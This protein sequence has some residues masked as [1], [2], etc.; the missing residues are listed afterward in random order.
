MSFVRQPELHRAFI[1][2]KFIF[3]LQRHELLEQHSSNIISN[4]KIVEDDFN[5][6]HAESLE[7]SILIGEQQL[8]FAVIDPAVY[9]LYWLESFQFESALKTEQLVQ[10]LETIFS[11]HEILKNCFW[12][13]IKV[14]IIN[15]KSTLL[16]EALFDENQIIK[17]FEI[18]CAYQPATE[19]VLLYRHKNA[20]I[21][22]LFATDKLLYELIKTQFSSRKVEFIPLGSI[23]IEGILHHTHSTV[24]PTIYINI[25]Y[26]LAS[27]AIKNGNQL[28]YFNSFH[29]KDFKDLLYYILFIAEEFDYT[30]EQ[31]T[32]VIWGNTGVETEYHIHLKDYINTVVLGN[33]ANAVSASFKFS[34]I[35]K[36]QFF[37]LLS[38]PLCS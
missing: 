25:G 7:L 19:Y 29:I 22:N 23:L 12:K 21:V 8:S 15:N 5:L 34:D 17:Y 9:R 24:E 13:T 11:G 18:N 20:E 16:P 4:L 32:V 31:L 27:F 26:E 33:R 6:E 38:M 30:Q 14:G 36:H 10:Q 1:K 28:Q 2:K 37:D 3:A 35:P